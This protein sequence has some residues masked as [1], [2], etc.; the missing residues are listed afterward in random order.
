MIEANERE[1]RSAGEICQQRFFS[2]KQTADILNVSEKS[3]RRLL[4]RGLLKSSNALRVK[5]IPRASI[6]AFE[7]ATC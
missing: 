2:V 6:E 1:F 7:K 4:E 3:V 5:R